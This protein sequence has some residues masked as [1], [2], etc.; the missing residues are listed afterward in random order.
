MNA[1]EKQA[2]WDCRHAALSTYIKDI[3]VYKCVKEAIPRLLDALDAAEREVERLKQELRE[4]AAF[5]IKDQLSAAVVQQKA[6]QALSG[7]EKG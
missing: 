3:Q 4:I 1:E 7:E 2:I 5:P 6:R